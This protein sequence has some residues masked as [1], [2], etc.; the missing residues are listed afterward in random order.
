MRAVRVLLVVYLA[1]VA[2]VTLGPAPAD[3]G[4]LS[5]VQQLA[6]WLSAHGLPVT[7]LGVEAV[8]NVVMFVPFGVLVSLALPA[9]TRGGDRVVVPLA[10]ATSA[11]IET[12]QRWLPTRVPTLQDVVLNTLG[13]ALGLLALR[14]LLA[15]RRRHDGDGVAARAAGDDPKRQA[16]SASRI[17]P[18]VK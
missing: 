18:S 7:Y 1:A 16:P 13:A 10:L 4:T 12:V 17:G 3:A 15:R 11:G 9:G 5:R 14:V 8:A 6:A 2:A